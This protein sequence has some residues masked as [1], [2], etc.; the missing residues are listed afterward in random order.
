MKS[1]SKEVEKT[2]PWGTARRPR[3][4]VWYDHRPDY[5]FGQLLACSSPRNPTKPGEISRLLSVVQTTNFNTCA[6][7]K[8]L[9]M[10][11]EQSSRWVRTPRVTSHP[12]LPRSRK[13]QE[14]ECSVKHV[15]H[16]ANAC[17]MGLERFSCC[18]HTVS[19]SRLTRQNSDNT[20]SF[21]VRGCHSPCVPLP[22]FF[23]AA[24]ARSRPCAVMAPP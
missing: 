16:G 3:L 17:T 12:E 18:K 7:G 13:R 20:K 1:T 15:E 9:L 10:L 21:D 4:A 11:D 23:D 5:S 19:S 22:G 8:T 2:T 6:A 14:I 24:H